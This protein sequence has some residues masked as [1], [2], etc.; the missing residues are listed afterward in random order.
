MEDRLD[1]VPSML[2]KRSDSLIWKNL[3]VPW[4]IPPD[5]CNNISER[6]VWIVGLRRSDAVEIRA[7]CQTIPS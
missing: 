6:G 3:S 4:K 1:R 2:R 5:R 7:C